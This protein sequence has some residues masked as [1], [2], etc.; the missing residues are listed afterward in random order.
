MRTASCCIL[1]G[2]DATAP[3]TTGHRTSYREAG[4][5]V[6][7]AEGKAEIN[8]AGCLLHATMRRR[9]FGMVFE[10]GRL[11]CVRRS[12][13]ALYLAV[14]HRD[15]MTSWEFFDYL[16]ETCQCGGHAGIRIR[17]ER[18]GIFP[19][20]RDSERM[21]IRWPHWSG[22]RRCKGFPD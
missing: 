16:L 19:S 14:A 5:A 13:R 9:L 7:S 8:R 4:E 20:D 1:C 11:Y 22:S 12:E 21:K 6:Y 10:G 3:S 15:K 18:R 17:T 2:R